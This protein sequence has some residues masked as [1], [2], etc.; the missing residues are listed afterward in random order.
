MCCFKFY[1]CDWTNDKSID[2]YN[3]IIS[4]VIEIVVLKPRPMP[5]LGKGTLIL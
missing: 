1:Q 2:Y 5:S 4:I 3:N